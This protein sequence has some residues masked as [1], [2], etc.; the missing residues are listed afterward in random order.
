MRFDSFSKVLAGGFRLGFVTAPPELLY[1]IEV[2][3]AATNL[4]AAAVSQMIIYK[5]LTHWGVEGFLANARNVALFYA[6][7]KGWFEE[8]AHRHL[9]GLARWT[10]PVAGLF[11]WVDCSESGVKNTSTFMYQYGIPHGIVACPGAS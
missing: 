1:P 2:L 3:T 4:H 11:L 5:I 6:G 8:I 10:S 9:D 7:R